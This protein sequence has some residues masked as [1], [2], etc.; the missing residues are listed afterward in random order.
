ME[1]VFSSTYCTIVASCAKGTTDSFL[2]PRRTRQYI[3]VQRGEDAPLCVYNAIDDFYHDV[4][5][6]ELNKRG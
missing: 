2:R 1:D 5:E 6:G 4:E 3:T